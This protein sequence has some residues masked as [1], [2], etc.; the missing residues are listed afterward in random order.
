MG[1]G[2]RGEG[3]TGGAGERARV[4]A[5]ARVRNRYVVCEGVEGEEEY[6]I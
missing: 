6:C 1:G 3:E 5:K 4:R 2:A